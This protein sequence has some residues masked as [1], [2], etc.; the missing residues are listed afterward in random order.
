MKYFG[1]KIMVP[2][3]QKESIIKSKLKKR[4]LNLTGGSVSG[5]PAAELEQLSLKNLRDLYLIAKTMRM[6]KPA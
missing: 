6:K 2:A 1:G 4:I 5:L 3:S